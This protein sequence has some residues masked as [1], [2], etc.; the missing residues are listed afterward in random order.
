MISCN[1]TIF[2]SNT[3]PQK[4]DDLWQNAQTMTFKAGG[5]KGL[6]TNGNLA[7]KERN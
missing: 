2:Y 1:G 7:F 5:E 4:N 6:M 3:V